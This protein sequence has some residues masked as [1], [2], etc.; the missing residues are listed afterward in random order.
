MFYEKKSRSKLWW[1]LLVSLPIV[2]YCAGFYSAFSKMAERHH[3]EWDRGYTEGYENGK[4]N[5][6]WKQ[7]A[8]AESKFTD[9][10]CTA[11]WFDSTHEDR[12][13][14]LEGKPKR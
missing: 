2:S 11:W 3:S 10:L 5:Q 14:S 4:L 1:V 12:R 7:L 8:K 13:I 6:D 9:K